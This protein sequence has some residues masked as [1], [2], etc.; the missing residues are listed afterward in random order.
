MRSDREHVYLKGT[1]RSST[2]S[3][4]VHLKDLIID[5]APRQ[6]SVRYDD[7]IVMLR[8]QMGGDLQR[9]INATL[10]SSHKDNYVVKAVS[11]RK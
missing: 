10:I 8:S 6:G 7:N 1:G 2:R 9:Y 5:Q 11:K 4:P 3:Y